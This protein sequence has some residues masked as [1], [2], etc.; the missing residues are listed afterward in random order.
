MTVMREGNDVIPECIELS[1]E[2]CG[3]RLL[4]VNDE[5]P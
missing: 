4:V 3:D 5:D 2:P 1:L